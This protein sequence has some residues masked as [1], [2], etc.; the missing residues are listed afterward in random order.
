VRG[1]PAAACAGPLSARPPPSTPLNPTLASSSQPPPPPSHSHRI[2]TQPPPSP[3]PLNRFHRR[4]AP[5]RLSTARP[6]ASP[7]AAS[8]SSRSTA[9]ARRCRRGTLRPTWSMASTTAGADRAW[10][11]GQEGG[12]AEGA[13]AVS[14]GQRGGRPLQ[15]PV[16]GGGPG[17]ARVG[18]QGL[19]PARATVSACLLAPAPAARFN[20][21]RPSQQ[22]TPPLWP[23]SP[24]PLPTPNP[25]APSSPAACPSLRPPSPPSSGRPSPWRSCPRGSSSRSTGGG[26]LGGLGANEGRR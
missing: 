11:W 13:R 5:S 9:T 20:A 22:P 14:A 3:L 24:P 8:W 2:G 7:S 23:P 12:G 1:L 17:R 26:R 4:Q 25:P 15:R 21:C 16:Q 10:L 18:V 19:V 6:A